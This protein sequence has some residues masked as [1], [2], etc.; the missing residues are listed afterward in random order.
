MQENNKNVM[1]RKGRPNKGKQKWLRKKR[2][3]E[4][5]N[6]DKKKTS[7]TKDKQ[8]K[9]SI[10]KIV[11]KILLLFGIPGILFSAL[12]FLYPE[13]KNY[14]ADRRDTQISDSLIF[15]LSNGKIEELRSY[16][17]NVEKTETGF[18]DRNQDKYYWLKG[19]CELYYLKP[20]D[21]NSAEKYF[22]K[23]DANNIDFYED[24]LLIRICKCEELYRKQYIDYTT[25]CN[26]IDKIL[27]EIN[28][29]RDFYFY[30][31]EFY[32]LKHS[33][34]ANIETIYTFFERIQKESRISYNFEKMNL[35]L[36]KVLE[37]DPKL[38]V[39]YQAC[40]LATVLY[41]YIIMDMIER[42]PVNAK[43]SEIH[44]K[45]V[46]YLCKFENIADCAE[47][48]K[49]IPKIIIHLTPSTIKSFFHE[50]KRLK[51]KHIE[52]L[53]ISNPNIGEVIFRDRSSVIISWPTAIHDFH[54][55]S[56]CFFNTGN[57]LC[58]NVDTL[59]VMFHDTSAENKPKSILVSSNF[60][61]IAKSDWLFNGKDE[62]KITILLDSYGSGKQGNIIFRQRDSIRNNCKVYLCKLPLF[63]DD[64]KNKYYNQR[65]EFNGEKV[66]LL[67]PEIKNDSLFNKNNIKISVFQKSFLDERQIYFSDNRTLVIEE[68]L[69]LVEED[70]C[71]HIKVNNSKSY[72][73]FATIREGVAKENIELEAKDKFIYI[74]NNKKF[75]L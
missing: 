12:L 38:L 71:I 35:I 15:L 66:E 19:H 64:Y 5:M 27:D 6:I 23:I 24:A 9:S 28:S 13:Y 73:L 58:I 14:L 69:L 65:L 11:G 7:F 50:I 31:A 3:K 68:S 57:S 2:K 4:S 22:S 53:I 54:K 59:G 47:F 26:A 36:T 8:P 43:E 75:I 25:Y 41:H 44:N 33:P 1:M 48:Y 30:Y 29:R 60:S 17:D 49:M 21:I 46:S 67:I 20:G 18:I 42:P 51:I 37:R 63:Q 34:Q 56:D 39:N 45:I 74:T 10:F 72:I 32:K 52:T 62:T 40:R 70:I 61:V 55:N 16:L